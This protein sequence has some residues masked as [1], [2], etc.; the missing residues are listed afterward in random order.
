MSTRRESIKAFFDRIAPQRRY[1]KR[2]AHYYHSSMTG[3]I[4]FI[5]PPGMRVLEVGCGTGELLAAAQPARGVGVD[6]SPEMLQRARAQFPAFEFVEADA[7]QLPLNE[8]FDYVIL[9]DIV[10]HL[11]DIQRCFEQLHKVTTPESRIIITHYNKLW[12]PI[13]SAAEA[14]RMKCPTGLQNW[15]TIGDIDNL[16]HLAGFETVKAGRRL[17]CPFAIPLIGW[18]CNRILGNL[19]LFNQL[20]L[21]KYAVAKPVVRT[22]DDQSQAFSA[23]VIIPTLN[24]AGNIE[25][26]I[27]RTPLMGRHTEIIFI[28]GH[29]TDGTV[30]KIQEMIQKY[31][32]RDIKF[33]YQ[34]RKGK[35]EAVFKGFDMASGDVLMILDSDLTMPPEDLPKF[36]EALANG[37]GEFING[38]RL[39]YPM[40]DQAMR[41]LNY[42][43]NHFFS[44]AFTW[45]LGQRIKDTL[46]GTKVLLKK[47]YEEIKRNR[48]FFGD[49]DPFGDFDLLFGAA[50]L[51]R[52]IVDMP[53]RYRERT[54]GEIK[55]HRFRH[56]ILLLKMCAFAARKIKFI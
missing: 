40:E 12:H 26:A 11:D 9:S 42:F 18:F 24:E 43:A 33:A 6:I 25:G 8:I 16:L 53:I 49:F 51:N 20:C 5:I 4:R 29:S 41:T 35:A 36:H 52:K 30:E 46:C 22:R 23:S 28:D 17:I 39:V 31:P 27:M 2:R 47:D 50:K 37:A 45:L 38:C 15:L 55:I 54:Y 13:M 48:S 44:L 34:D 1:W 19:P 32:D 3:L 14:M 10:G 56:G 21:V 7:H